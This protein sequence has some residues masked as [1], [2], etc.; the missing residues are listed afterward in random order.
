LAGVV[1]GPFTPGFVG[2]AHVATQ[3]D[4][5]GIVLL[6]FGVGLH[7]SLKDLIEVKTIALPG[8]IA[9]IITATGLGAW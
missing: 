9:Q 1:I 4:E 7:F 2:D 8:A 5:I 3:L 6:M